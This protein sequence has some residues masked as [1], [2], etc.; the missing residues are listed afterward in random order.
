VSTDGAIDYEVVVVGETNNKT[1]AEA[2]GRV[3][4]FSEEV[5]VLEDVEEETR[6]MRSRVGS[7]VG[8][9]RGSTTGFNGQISKPMAGSEQRWFG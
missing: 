2:D 6:L 8:R 9:S 1:A 5:N 4:V 7:L 3:V